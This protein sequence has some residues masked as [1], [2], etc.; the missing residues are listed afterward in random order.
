[1]GTEAEMGT[2]YVHWQKTAFADGF[3]SDADLMEPYRICA[4]TYG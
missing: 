4:S 3:V 2:Q 1:M